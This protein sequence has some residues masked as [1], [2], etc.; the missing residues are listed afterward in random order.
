MAESTLT[1]LRIGILGASFNPVH[2]GHLR[3]ALEMREALALAYVDLLPC[4]LPPHKSA[5][6]ILPFDLRVRLLSAAVRGLDGL[7]VNLMEGER[8]GPSYTWDSLRDYAAKQP[9]ARHFFILGCEDFCTLPQ[10]RNGLELPQLA[11]FVVVPRDGA[12]KERF[13]QA[14][15]TNWPQALPCSTGI[16]PHMA[17]LSDADAFMLPGGARL[18]YLPLTRLDISASLLRRRFVTGLDIQFLLPP[19]SLECLEAERGVV[20]AYWK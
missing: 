8:Q 1:P 11:D 14:V 2:I 12:G 6:G 13:A 15:C 7:R 5:A 4:A 9:G 3:L 18:L 16:A 17:E 10:W 19:A 20:E